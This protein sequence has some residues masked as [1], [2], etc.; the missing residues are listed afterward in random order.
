M[1]KRES[2]NYQDDRFNLNSRF[3]WANFDS[4]FLK[5]NNSERAK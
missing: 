1:L 3:W 5:V 2:I 4:V